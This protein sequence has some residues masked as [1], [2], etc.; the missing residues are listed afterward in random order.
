MALIN[1]EKQFESIKQAA[2]Q[3]IKTIFP[4][5]KDKHELILNNVWVE[6]KQD[7]DDYSAQTKVKARGGSWG[8]SVYVD[9]T[10]RDKGTKKIIDREKKI[11]LFLLPK[12][13]QRASYIVR[14]NEYQ[15]ANQL[16]LKAGAYV[17]QMKG[18]GFKTQINLSKGGINSCY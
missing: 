14:G 8:A 9:L 2:I 5:S 15:V 10:L 7:V 6:D 4:A 13:T 16:R 1:I 17:K 18:G 11:K 12:L 3:A